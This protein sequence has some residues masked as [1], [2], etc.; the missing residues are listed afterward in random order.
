MEMLGLAGIEP[1]GN[2]EEAAKLEERR[3]KRLRH[4]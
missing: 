2:A 4:L 1:L 3:R